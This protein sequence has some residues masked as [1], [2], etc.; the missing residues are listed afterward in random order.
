MEAAMEHCRPHAYDPQAVGDLLPEPGVMLA[1]CDAPACGAVTALEV[2][3][4]L[5]GYLKRVSISRLQD[6]L[7]CTCGS[8]R[9]RLEAWPVNLPAPTGP[10]RLYLFL[11]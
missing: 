1:R 5:H 7:R 4:D 10:R 9:G 11:I 3:L 8:R 6:Q 2:G